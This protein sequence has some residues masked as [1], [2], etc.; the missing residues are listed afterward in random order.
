MPMVLLKYVYSLRNSSV[1]YIGRNLGLYV[2]GSNSYYTFFYYKS[3]CVL[4]AWSIVYFYY[5]VIQI[6]NNYYLINAFNLNNDYLLKTL[7]GRYFN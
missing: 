2:T 7:L 3:D 4:S 6:C 5:L 1:R